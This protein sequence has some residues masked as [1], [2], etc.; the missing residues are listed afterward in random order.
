MEPKRKPSRRIQILQAAA[1]VFARLGFDK[2]TIKQ[3]AREAG[4]RAPA[5]IYW[6]YHN[7][8]ALFQAVLEKYSLLTQDLS[9]PDRLDSQPPEQVLT[10]L[11]TRFLHTFEDPEAVRLFR[12]LLA[13]TAHNEETA[14]YFA[15]RSILPFQKFLV[16]Y[17][18]KQAQ[19][20]R[21]RFHNAQTMARAFLGSLV[22][23]VMAQ[24]LFPM[25]REGQPAYG[26]Y[27]QEVVQTFLRGLQ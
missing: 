1:R 17:L 10:T 4:M 3:I 16:K 11:G 8:R 9:D 23:Y 25:V 18:E 5:L 20:G 27:V 7:K 6:Y 2:A 14:T 15:E 13:E 12:I 26:D 19:A 21:L 24:G 22:M